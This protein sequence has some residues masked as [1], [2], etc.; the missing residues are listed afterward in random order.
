MEKERTTIGEETNNR[1][2]R[3]AA[4][5]ALAVAKRDL[6]RE[7]QALKEFTTPK[8]KDKNGKSATPPKC[9]GKPPPKGDDKPPPR[10]LVAKDFPPAALVWVFSRK[11]IQMENEI[12]RKKHMKS[13]FRNR[14]V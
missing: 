1:L 7:R 4:V 5:E 13:H 9:D 14:S 2:K 10:D 8:S 6:R 11:I 12:N 3:K